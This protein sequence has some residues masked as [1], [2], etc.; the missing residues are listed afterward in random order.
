M[1]KCIGIITTFENDNVLKS[2][3]SQ[4]GISTIPIAGKY[5]AID[6]P[7]SNMINGEI[8]TIGILSKVNCRSLRDHLE[9]GKSWGLTR[10]NGGLLIF[11]DEA[12]GDTDL[13]LKNLDFLLRSNDEYVAIST[14]R[15]ILNIDLKK[16]IEF[17]ENSEADITVVYKNIDENS[18]EFFG[19]DTLEFNEKNSLVRVFEN[20]SISGDI[21]I[22]SEIFLLRKTLLIS[23]LESRIDNDITLKDLIYKTRKKLNIQGYEYTGFLGCINNL[24]NYFKLNI[25]LKNTSILKELFFNNDRPI[26]SKV[27]DAIPTYYSNDCKIQDSIISN[28]CY[29]AGDIKNSIL[30]RYVTVEEGAIVENSII[31]QNCTIKSGVH[32]KN[33]IIDKDVIL[34]EEAILEG[35]PEYP[36]VIQKKF[37]Y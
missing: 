5:R 10:K 15:M 29:I 17:H 23:I 19:C 33:A 34:K 14:S 21:N 25:E 22:S 32:L 28:E 7:L 18:K 2:L 11:T 24:A 16:V 3:T 27:K 4:R 13:L 6:F 36:L 12:K 30:A 9:T 20:F 31:F 26:Y 8:K 1:G 35:H 37:R